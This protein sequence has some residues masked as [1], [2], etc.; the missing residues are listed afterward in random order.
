MLKAP[1]VSGRG[2]H[3]FAMNFKNVDLL[4]EQALTFHNRGIAHRAKGGLDAALQDFTEAIRLKPDHAP[5]FNNRGNARSA[6]GDLDGALQ[7]F[8]EAIR[9]K[10]DY[11]LAFENRGNARRVKGDLDGALRDFNAGE[12]SLREPSGRRTFDC[13]VLSHEMNPANFDCIERL[14]FAPFFF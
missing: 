10:P 6:K 4:T 7:D 9:L 3:L 13:S 8:N 11:A 12:K 2:E 14:R 1:R 5:A